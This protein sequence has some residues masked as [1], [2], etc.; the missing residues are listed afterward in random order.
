MI[1]RSFN[2]IMQVLRRYGMTRSQH[3]K[4]QRLIRI[5]SAGITHNATIKV[6]S[7]IRYYEGKPFGFNPQQVKQ[8]SIV[9]EKKLSVLEN[10]TSDLGLATM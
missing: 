8:G 9:D 5:K 4:D 10:V 6:P 2:V 3:T 1:A 7:V